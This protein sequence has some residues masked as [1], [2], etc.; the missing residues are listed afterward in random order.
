M[1]GLRALSTPKGYV[2]LSK[3]ESAAVEAYQNAFGETTKA[4]GKGVVSGIKTRI[5]G[6]AYTTLS[7]T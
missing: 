3:L 2:A 6:A 5:N 1:S 7:K 4:Y